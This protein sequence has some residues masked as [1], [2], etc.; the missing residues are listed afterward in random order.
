MYYIE[1]SVL[2]NF[3][4]LAVTGG[5]SYK[6]TVLVYGPSTSIFTKLVVCRE[7][8]TKYGPRFHRRPQY[9]MLSTPYS[10]GGAHMST[11]T[12]RRVL[13]KP[14]CPHC[15]V[16]LDLYDLE[17]ASKFFV[18]GIEFYC[19]NPVCCSDDRQR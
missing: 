16:A 6:A 4:A 19:N 13:K 15:G 8:G 10:V 18:G 2:M 12:S 1:P 14:I 17:Y 5:A 3:T 11:G 9:L 7:S